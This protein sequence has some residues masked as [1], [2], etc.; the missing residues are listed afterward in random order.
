VER[1]SD[2]ESQRRSRFTNLEYGLAS[3]LK[4]MAFSPGAEL[5]PRLAQRSRVVGTVK[6]QQQTGFVTEED[7][8]TKTIKNELL[9]STLMV[10]AVA[11]VTASCGAR[12]KTPVNGPASDP[13]YGTVYGAGNGAVAG[14]GYGMVSVNES[15][16][17]AQAFDYGTGA[18]VSSPSAFEGY[19]TVKVNL[20]KRY[21]FVDGTTCPPQP[22]T[23]RK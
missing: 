18:S 14:P 21:G 20:P 3:T 22:M 19:D 7:V 10:I 5:G 6:R 12:H 13:G 17:Q 9:I 8:M 4:S 2:L 1:Y 23:P 16:G 15:S 11:L